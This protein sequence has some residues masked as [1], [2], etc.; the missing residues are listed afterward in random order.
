MIV[1]ITGN[2]SY[3]ARRKLDELTAEFVKKYGDLAVEKFDGEDVDFQA[4]L[5]AVQAT[6]FLSERKL[7]TVRGAAA[8]KDLAEQIEQI[9][10]SV[11]E[12]TDLI[13][14]E[15]V[16]DKRTL[17]YKTLKAKTD[18]QEYNELD[19]P[20]LAKWLVEEAKKQGAELGMADANYMVQRMG[21]NQQ[22]LA[23]ELD[24]LAT[25]DKQI[26]RQNIDLLTEPTPQSKIF[27]LLDAAFGDNKQNALKLYDE[28]R[29]QK[30]EP[31]A[32]LA[33]LEW[34]LDILALC[35]LAGNKPPAQIASDAGISP[36]PVTKASSLARRI[37]DEQ[38]KRL[39]HEALEMDYLSKTKTYDLDEA[40]KTY[41]TLI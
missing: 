23:V 4:V 15:P 26:S 36:F 31:A 7:V 40:L 13:F 22:L 17:F 11:T 34:Q 1:T 24:K 28:Q 5:D 8:N 14:Y 39:V 18:F 19:G 21:Q 30:V 27:D 6:P 41:I 3:A 16:T 12:S 2:N 37:S 20:A 33:M 38:L 32:I 25:Y 29:A 35:K 10:S 9:I